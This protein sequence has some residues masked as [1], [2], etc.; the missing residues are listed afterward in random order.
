MS[1]LAK[2][3]V[4]F[5]SLT[6]L[7]TWG[8]HAHAAACTAIASTAWNLQTTWGAA[9]TGCVGPAGGIPGAAD[10]V[11]VPTTFTVT[12]T[13]AAAATS[14]TINGT[15][16][17]VN[18]N[19]LTISGALA[20]TG[21]L[22]NGTAA[23]VL[24]IGGNSTLTTL[25]A[26]AAGNTVNYTGAAQTA[27]V[28][29][30]SN[31]TLSGSLAKT[32]AT[33]P[34][35]NGVL[36]M[37]GTATVTATVGVVTYGANATLQYNKP[38]AYT[39]TA[40]EWITPF[41][42]TG[43][44]IIANIGAI[45]LNVAK[46]F[47]ASVPLTINSGATLATGNLGIT[48]GGNFVNNGG[49]FTAGSSPIVIANTMVA[50]S[51]AGFTTTGLVSMTK[52][53]GMATFTGNVSGAGLTNN[54]AGGTL[55]LGAGL[56]HTFTGVVTLTNGTLNGGSSTLNE[57]ATSATAW[58]GTGTNFT[59]STG[60][61]VFGAAGN[62]TLSTT[63]TFNNLT[64]SGS[65]TKTPAAGTYTIAGNF[66][67]NSGVTYAGN[68][69]NPA[70]N[71]A[72]NF[73]NSGTFTAGTGTI[74]FNGTNSTLGGTAATTFNNLTIN[75]TVNNNVSI[76]CATPSPTVNATLTLTSG[77][78]VTSGISPGCATTCATQVPVI[79]AAAGTITGGSSSSYV[80]GALRKMFNAAA[81]LNF[82]AVAGQDEFP[83]GD[84]SNYSPVEI[85]AGTTS[86]AGNITACVTPTDHPQVTA[87]VATTGINAAKSVN[88]YWSLT[89]ATINTTAV[90]VDAT[91]KFVAGDVDGGATTANF[92]VEDYGTYWR[93]TTLVTAAAT[94]T[95][96][97]NLDLTPSTNN[98]IAIGEPLSGFT[99]LPGQYNAF[100]TATPAGAILGKIQTKVAGTG[101]SMD[102]VNINAAKTGVQATAIT[103][104]VRLLDSSGG[105]AL[106]VNGCNAAWP[107]IQALPN[108]N[109]PA[110]G[111]GTIPAA[112]V[113][114]SYRS[115]RFQIR[116]PP[117]GPY[118][119][120]GCSTDLFAIRPSGFTILVQDLNRA[121]AGTTN[122]LNATTVAGVPVHNAGQPFR[123]QATA[124]NASAVTTTNYIGTPTIMPLS[125]CAG[126]ACPTLLNLGTF[127]IGTWPAAVAG[128]TN[129]TTATYS[130]VGAFTLQLQDT[131]FASVDAV[132]GTP[133][134]CIG[135]WVCSS[136]DVGRFVPDHFA[137]SGGSLVN[138]S[139]FCALGCGTFTYMGEPMNAVFTLT[140]MNGA[141]IP[142]TTQ[143]YTYT[144]TNN[145]AKLI[146]TAAV[147]P[148]TSGPL[149]L[150]VI[151][152][153]APR[154]PFPVCTAAP[155][156]P[157]F[158]PL[159]ATAGS[160][161]SG[162]ATGITVPLT[163]YR[164]A[165]AVGPFAA[166]NI[167]VAPVDSDSV[168]TVYDL[169]TVNTPVAVASNHT[170][171]NLSV[172]GDLL[173]GRIKLSN[174]YGSELL[175]L[176]ITATVQYWNGSYVTSSTD[177]ATQFNT[178]LFAAGGNVQ[179]T[180]VK[181]PLALANV[182][183]VTPG[184]VTFANGINTFILAAPTVTGS[185][186]L[187]IV[188]APSYL[189]PSTTGR[190]TFSVYKGANEFI[191]QRENY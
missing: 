12:V 15:G 82:R 130:E 147:T 40:E 56:T 178:K 91:F 146:P 71:L 122:T 10:T 94:S 54:G 183:V 188:T 184:T 45:T 110:S 66:T 4:L 39:A 158:T 35:V 190:A 157:C 31:L 129:S 95:R 176:P 6:G 65:G 61:V 33:T 24:N 20:G 92:I 59:A 90:P 154:T 136:V 51:I 124:V 168:T 14:L 119:Q 104:E 175:S 97:Q 78:I 159:A 101:F 60:T 123:V 162:V 165:A 52:T 72:G 127:S 128:V 9:G 100:E 107:L 174:A 132:D 21:G 113:S 16:S 84:T 160:F 161:A 11:T 5:V 49:T 177:S 137:V 103:V 22:T 34:T 81:T 148:Y 32:F 172:P 23:S 58:N 164:G 83:V 77:D 7:L 135:Q 155:A 28:T 125:A 68:T 96:V 46:V 67:V 169:D 74:T 185:V 105:G 102:V 50:Q 48:F 38:A 131:S 26:T 109:I 85:T 2:L 76:V 18:N 121:T 47:N 53:A 88:R 138:R 112:T 126:T 55:N 42:A 29:T 182:S 151:D 17:V 80:Q 30:Y 57:N 173:Y 111:R 86:T 73:S 27:K 117:L 70:V 141:A 106:D 63:S 170:N 149:G 114:N 145:L 116:S 75:K 3:F 144:A 41:A 115:V 163:V 181:G 171:L 64:F 62:Q 89:T 19:T 69:N 37:E 36:S 143:N 79:V 134:S 118:T 186:D 166:L 8:G 180:I 139:D 191:Y 156:H 167:G 150:G 187:N 153:A 140:A 13:A 133:A 142:A 189:L 152:T 98:D 120:I 43:G 87:P 93:P 44:V 99:A 25:T 179:P 1:S 108:F